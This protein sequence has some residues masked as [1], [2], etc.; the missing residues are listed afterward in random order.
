MAALNVC[1]AHSHNSPVFFESYKILVQDLVDQENIRIL[2]PS[3]FEL[4]NL[5]KVLNFTTLE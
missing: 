4:S 1:G 3:L 5:V 2:T